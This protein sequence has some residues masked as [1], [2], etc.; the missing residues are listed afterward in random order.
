M[1]CSVCA[2]HD[3]YNCPCCGEPV[4]MI[5]CPDCEGSGYTPPM[6]FDIKHRRFVKVTEQAYNILP[7]DEDTADYMGMRYC[8]CE[9]EI[10]PT[11]RGDGKIPEDY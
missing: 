1:S 4:R 3:S 8:K 2:G 9:V 10:C 11:C 6:A 7:P 5:T